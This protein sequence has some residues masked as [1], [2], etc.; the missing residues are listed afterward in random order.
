MESGIA[1]AVHSVEVFVHALR[2]PKPELWEVA[3]CVGGALGIYIL[4]RLFSALTLRSLALPP[5]P[6]GNPDQHRANYRVPIHTEVEISWEGAPMSFPGRASELSAGGATL[7]IEK[8]RPVSS[9]LSVRFPEDKALGELKAQVIQAESSKSLR[10]HTLHCLFLA[11][12]PAQE[13]HLLH[14]VAAREREMIL[15]SHQDLAHGCR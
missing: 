1:Q 10:R 15:A 14:K 11:P 7:H 9:L 8:V 4:L 3:A 2:F 13:Q 5:G 12:T 6:S